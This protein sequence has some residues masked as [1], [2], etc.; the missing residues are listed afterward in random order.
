MKQLPNGKGDF[1]G[2]RDSCLEVKNPVSDATP[3]LCIPSRH[4]ELKETFC[5]DEASSENENC[6]GADKDSSSTW[7]PCLPFL[8]VA[9]PVCPEGSSLEATKSLS[10]VVLGHHGTN[11]H[12]LHS[13]VMAFFLA[14]F[15]TRHKT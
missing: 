14:M 5:R 7:H 9:T 15:F 4:W 1:D 3:S 11:P 2:H 13:Q 6:W 10:I 12:T 8:L